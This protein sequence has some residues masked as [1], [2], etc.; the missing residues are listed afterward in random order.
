[1]RN[2]WELNQQLK[3]YA[4]NFAFIIILPHLTCNIWGWANKQ[5]AENGWFNKSVGYLTNM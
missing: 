4:H 3:H 2:I 5:Y 1:M